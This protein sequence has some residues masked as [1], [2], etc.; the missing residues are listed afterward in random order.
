MANAV[1]LVLFWFLVLLV[2]KLCLGTHVAKLCFA[3]L[4]FASL[5]A[6]LRDWRSQ[7]ELGN[8]EREERD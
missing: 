2:P 5:E 8:E 1:A 3:S 6:E 7:A 4:Y